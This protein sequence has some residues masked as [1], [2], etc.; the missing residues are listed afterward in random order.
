MQKL[1]SGGV[2]YLDSRELVDLDLDLKPAKSLPPKSQT[3]S[4][5]TRLEKKTKNLVPLKMPVATLAKGS[6]RQ[7]E[8]FLNLVN[9]QIYKNH[10]QGQTQADAHQVLPP[11]S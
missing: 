11:Q 3:A 10:L 6:Q 5:P 7:L 4:R 2:K 9:M 8:S 1:P